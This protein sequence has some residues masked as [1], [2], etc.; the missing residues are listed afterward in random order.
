MNSDLERFQCHHHLA[1]FSAATCTLLRVG[2]ASCRERAAQQTQDIGGA[3]DILGPLCGPSRHKAAPT[4]V[5]SDLEGFQCH[6]HLALFSAATCTLLRVG[7]ASCRERAAQQPQDI[8]GAADILGPLCGPSRH[9]AAPTGVNSD[10]EGFQ[11]H[12][13]LAL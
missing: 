4:G 13:H 11:C 8:G 6:H 10:L 7:A 9:K 1:L 5:N 3:A 12:H 2:A